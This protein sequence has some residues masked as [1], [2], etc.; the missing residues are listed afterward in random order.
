MRD[1]MIPD[2]KID[3]ALRSATEVQI[4]PHFANRVIARL[5]RLETGSS[6]SLWIRASLTLAGVSIL[7]SLGWAGSV[8]GF[9]QWIEQPQA[10]TSILAIEAAA[11]LVWVWRMSRSVR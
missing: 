6:D 1:E 8:L 7:A 3:A 10:Y 9:G 2:E 11:T 4:P 5:P